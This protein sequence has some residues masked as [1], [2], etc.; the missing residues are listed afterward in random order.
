MARGADCKNCPLWDCKQGPV[1][2][3]IVK[4]APLI[5]IG[6]APGPQEVDKRVPFVGASGGVLDTS[7]EAGGLVR[8]AISV[9]NTILCKPPGDGNFAEYVATLQAGYARSL[10]R[11]ER[12]W[13]PDTQENLNLTA[14]RR[15]KLANEGWQRGRERARAEGRKEPDGPPSLPLMPEAACRPR[16]ERDIA[17]SNSRVLLA[18]GARALEA[19]RVYLGL[20]T[21]KEKDLPP[22]APRVAGIKRQHGAPILLEDG[23]V[24]MSSYHPAFAMRDKCEYMPVIRENITRAAKV[25]RRYGKV[26]WEEPPFIIHPDEETILRTLDLFLDNGAEVTVDVETDGID[27]HVCRLRCVG[28]GAVIDGKE[29]VI[30][31]PFNHTDGTAWWPEDA[32]VRIA[33]KLRQVL[34]TLPL[35]FQNGTYDTTVL[36][37][38]GLMTRRDKD[39]SDTLLLHHDTP[40]NDLPHDLGFIV[41]RYFEVPMWKESVDH[42]TADGSDYYLHKYNCLMTG[43]P[44]VCAD[45]RSR[46]IEN[47]VR[48]RWD[49]EVL[50]RSPDGRVEAR[51]VV[52][53]HRQRVPNQSWVRIRTTADRASTRGL[54]VTPDHNIYTQRGLLRADSLRA[55]DTMYLAES[56]FS[57][58]QRQAVLGTLLGDSSVSM[59]PDQRRNGTKTAALQGSHTRAGGLA[60]YKA[61]VLPQLVLG[62]ERPGGPCVI[63]GKRTTR[64]P[65]T[66]YST[67]QLHQIGELRALLYDVQGHKRLRPAVLDQLGAIGLAWWY[68]DDGCVQKAKQD[69]MCFATNGFL[70]EDVDTAVA[71]FRTNFGATSAGADKVIRLAARASRKLAALIAPH[72]IPGLRYKLPRGTKTAA[73]HRVAQ[74]HAPLPVIVTEAKAFSAPR[75]TKGQRMKAETRWCITVEENHNFFTS[76]G[77]VKNCKDV[78]GTMRAVQ[79]LRRLV[80]D[81]DT[82]PQY[83]TDRKMAVRTRDMNELGLVCNEWL[84]GEFST[85]LNVQCRQLSKEFQELAGRPI[86]P[87]SP[88][89]LRELF[90][91]DWEYVP[92]VATDGFDFEVDEDDI[93]DASTSNQAL[94]RLQTDRIIRENHPHY[95]A[96]EKLLAFRANDKIRGTY[97]DKLPTYG[98]DWDSFGFGG[99]FS[100][101]YA[102]AVMG[103]AYDPDKDE[104]YDCEL[105]PRRRGLSLVRTTYKGHVV[106]TGRLASGD[107]VNFQN[108]PK[109]A[110]GNLNLRNMYVAPPGHV[111][112]GADY[113]QIEARLYAIIAQDRLLLKAIRDKLDIHSLNAASLT[114]KAGADVMAEYYALKSK[115]KAEIDHIRT[116]AKRFCFGKIYGA[117]WPMI[118]S[119]MSADR[120][121]ATGERTFPKLTE[122]DCQEW[123]DNWDRLHP[124]TKWWHERCHAAFREY[125]FTG[126]PMLDFR[127]RF[128]PGGVAQENAIPNLTIQG[129]AAS[130]AN[131]ALLAIA[132]LIPYRGWSHWSGLTLQVHDYIGVVVPEARAYEAKKII[133]KCMFYS[134]EGMDFTATAEASWSWGAQ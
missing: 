105:I 46:L 29:V 110:R 78:L 31:V 121:K 18:V 51:R 61:Q 88:Q 101:G 42:K 54:I 17:E 132:E 79:P 40:D 74:S 45:G 99:L 124:E 14:A 38:V 34:D 44:V 41:R 24:L 130:I 102:P 66:N 27:A 76:F 49:G 62:K 98:V 80:I 100:V 116:V 128:F 60:E 112:V 59:S 69:T 3:T 23:R 93:E 113:E 16:L 109:S 89:Q 9:T 67:R 48:H 11:W 122:K 6:E 35:V 58:E 64:A 126:A 8:S 25:A 13:I 94:S 22:E 10:K 32:K 37:R 55:G 127:K 2:G 33:M 4:D 12:I 28:L 107:P 111:I 95:I 83:M 53:W 92:V 47:I 21:S 77:L 125:G 1:P 72:I 81:H 91:V 36:L 63:K 65:S 114:C 96:I 57:V 123:S 103:R 115:P 7:L 106:P 131:R 19:C 5:A 85:K 129:S 86:N 75:R 120:K 73:L 104:D 39:W 108:V 97:V 134:Y 119:V 133:E 52:D 26:E 82:V 87:R 118:F 30:S 84:R 71:W 117:D 43:T 68:M 90:Y 15:A 50:S 20:P 56:L 70:R